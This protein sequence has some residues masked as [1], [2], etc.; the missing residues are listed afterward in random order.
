M[1]I[2][3]QNLK[4]RLC[5]VRQTLAE[6]N[7]DAAIVAN[8]SNVRYLSGFEGDDSWLIVTEKNLFLITDSRYTLQAKK[9]CPLCKI[10]ER[11]TSI[12]DAACDTLKK[13]KG[14]KTVCIENRVEIR[15]FNSLQKKLTVSLKPIG[16]LVE[17]VR[18]IKDVAEIAAIKLAGKIAKKA[19]EKV[20][21]G[22]Y[23]GIRE[24]ELA[25]M[26]DYE[27]KKSGA[28]PAFETIVAFGSNSAMPHHRPTDRKLKKND[29]ILIDFG[30][31]FKGYCC[32]ITRCFAVGK[33]SK[34]YKKVYEAVFA[35]QQ[36]AIKTV[37]AGQSL[38]AVDNAAR[39]II[40]SAK[41][42]IYGHG[43]GHGLGLEVHESPTIS[44]LS[45]DN[46]KQGNVITIEPAVY[47]PGKFGI[48]IEDDVLVANSGYKT[49]TSTL[50]DAYV[51]ILKIS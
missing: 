25:A 16:N 45:K 40:K 34:L 10:V 44:V 29:T 46:L 49:I 13:I 32:D 35:A 9:Q 17:A 51:P 42:P 2:K 15:V 4:N 18:Q 48:R 1:H 27:M 22:I 8:T 14:V 5:Q 26:L 3:N 7:F 50:N 38:I 30:A 12:I 19:L 20:L 33:V 23:S 47:L 6:K 39:G 36:S 28:M 43:T 11:K 21:S 24:T 37:R 41:L 31:K